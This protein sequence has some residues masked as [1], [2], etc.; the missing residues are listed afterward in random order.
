MQAVQVGLCLLVSFFA[1]GVLDRASSG[2]FGIKVRAAESRS[3]LSCLSRRASGELMS[4]AG[5]EDGQVLV[6]GFS[7]ILSSS[8]RAGPKPKPPKQLE[9]RGFLGLGGLIRFQRPRLVVR[10]AVFW[11]P[12][13]LRLVASVVLPAPD[14][15]VAP[16]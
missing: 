14:T 4:P 12:L 8:C 1:D 10:E 6:S 15:E 13:R 9:L 11:W 7:R 2:L 16:S 3:S 5:L